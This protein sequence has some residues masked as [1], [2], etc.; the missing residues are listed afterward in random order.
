MAI[1]SACNEPLEDLYTEIDAQNTGVIKDMVITL[2]EDDYDFLEGVTGAEG[3]FRFKNFDN[4][5]GMKNFIPHILAGKFPQLGQGSSAIV[6]YNFYNGSSPDLRGTFTEVTVPSADYQALGFT[7]GNFGNPDTDVSNWANYKY[8]DASDGDY[9]DVTFIYWAPGVTESTTRVVYSVAYGW[10][11]AVVLPEDSYGDV[12]GES[13]PDF[14]N[15]DEGAEKI[16]LW[17][18]QTRTYSYDEEGDKILVQYNYDNGSGT[19]QDVALYIF[20]GTDYL[21]YEDAYQT[22]IESFSFAHDGTQWIADNTVKYTLGFNDYQAIGSDWDTKNTAGSTSILTYSNFDTGAL[23]TEEQ[24]FEAITELLMELFPGA[25]EGQK[26]LVTYDTWEPGAGTGQLYVI[27]E[28]G[29]YVPF[30]Q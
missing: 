19:S 27:L 11:P 22:T 2:E 1:C 23:W 25:E 20:D 26:Y 7:F 15:S 4:Q 10:L 28:G 3:S 24:I 12:F 13:P 17:L 29:Q 8:P 18:K 21:L 9:A 16:P 6:S 5:D 30:E 14:S